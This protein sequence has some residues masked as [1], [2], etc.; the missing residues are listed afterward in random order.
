MRT[1][2]KDEIQ[3]GRSAEMHGFDP[4]FADPPAYILGITEQIWEGRE[5]EALHDL[6]AP[7]IPVRSP[8][9]SIVGN[10]TVIAA[11][12]ATLGEFPDRQLLGEDVIWS[13]DPAGGFLSS[14]RIFS[15]ATHAGAGEFG[16]PTGT[17]LHYRVIADCAARDN[18]IYDEWIVRD[19]GA[20]ARQLGSGPREMA[21]ARLNSGQTATM[22][23]SQVDPA[24][25]YVGVGNDDPHGQRYEELVGHRLDGGDASGVD[26]D[27]DRAIALV[28]PGGGSHHGRDEVDQFWAGLRT[29][30][31]GAELTVHHRIGRH[32]ADLGTRAALRWSLTGRHDGDGPFGPATGA[33]VHV[34]AISH[35]EFGPWGLRREWVLFDEVAI[36]QQILGYTG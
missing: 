4:S 32:D 36:W 17:R 9:G 13:A 23:T 18:V 25:V 31:P 30:F 24:P 8:A 11:T 26:G 15:T 29:A 14:H 3:V 28:A 7:E 16:E 22:A 27:V 19:L 5:V 10:E 12:W 1:N 21:E 34:M 2:S 20:I 6:Y 33:P 35:A